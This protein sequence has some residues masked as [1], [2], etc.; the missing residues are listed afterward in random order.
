MELNN[1]ALKPAIEPAAPTSLEGLDLSPRGPVHPSPEDWA[2]QILY[3]LLPDRFSDGR[4]SSRPLFDPKQHDRFRNEHGRWMK[5]GCCF[6]GG[7]LGG[8]ESK[9]DY[10]RSLGVTTLW[11]A[12]IFK[13]RADL[14]TYHGYG[15][16]N[17]LDVDP[18]IGTRQDLRSLVDAAHA[19]G[20]Y[21]LLDVIYNH[22]G[23]NFFYDN[24][25]DPWETMPY[26]ETGAHP[27]HG[28][29]SKDG[30][31][32]RE[33]TGPDDGVWPVEFQNPD[34]YTRAGTIRN[35]DDPSRAH[36]RDAE[37]RRGDFREMK[38]LKLEDSEV[39]DAVV[40]C[41]QYW[42][43]LSDCDGFRIDTVKHIP[44]EVSAIF[45]HD[46]RTFARRIGKKNFLLLGEV[47]GTSDFVRSYVDPH[48]PNLD[49][50]LDIESAP[51]RLAG[52]VKGLLPPEE[53]FSHFGGRDALGDVRKVGRHHVSILDDHDMVG[54]DGKHRFAWNN[55]SADAPAQSAHAVGVQLTT[56]GIPCIY[57]GTEQCFT[58]SESTH[59]EAAEPRGVDGLV[60]Y[61]DRYVRECMFGGEFGAFGTTG[62]HFFNGDHPAYVRIAAIARL[63]NRADRVGTCLRRGE[64]YVRET[65]GDGEAA[66]HPPAAGQIVAWVRIDE[67]YSVKMA[68]NTHGL[69]ARAADVTVDANLHPPGSTVRVLY[70]S[71]WGDG[72]LKA[73]EPPA[74]AVV[75]VARHPDGRATVR[76]ELPPAGMAIFA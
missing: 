12:P 49:S 13:Q 26:Q 38:D 42:I 15:I 47:T 14:Q 18:R 1:T 54:R 70:R 34:W 67:G 9:L 72:T 50:V 20:M 58:G 53:F 74:D 65:R 32:V 62:V 31:S 41:Y 22:T 46:I 28:W 21:V 57:Y 5:S 52:M 7:T 64:L 11:I 71:D 36:S 27:I 45:C 59:D 40:R 43:A 10:L 60:P 35:W 66:F 37:F 48:G 24:N 63:R 16:Q 61:A 39:L 25:G 3:F 33:I 73:S 75:P 29:R 2:D 8:V 76:V 69:E 55:T 19:R 17:F 6:Q 56:P 44:H 23:N 30:R 51:R 4:E 68:L